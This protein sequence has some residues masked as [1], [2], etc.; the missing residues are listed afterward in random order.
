MLN[1]GSS[2]IRQGKPTSMSHSLVAHRCCYVSIHYNALYGNAS[3]AG[4]I[5]LRLLQNLRRNSSQAFMTTKLHSFIYIFSD[6]SEV[7]A[8]TIIR[9]M[10]M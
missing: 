7:L 8:D 6:V 2:H 9:A 4:M 1:E 5:I 10:M 3:D